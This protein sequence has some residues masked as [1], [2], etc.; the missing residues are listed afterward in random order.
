MGWMSPLLQTIEGTRRPSTCAL[1]GVDGFL[2]GPRLQPVDCGEKQALN[3]TVIPKLCCRW[4]RWHQKHR[5]ETKKGRE[6]EIVLS[7][8]GQP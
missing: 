8:Q 5:K 3:N 1:A 7:A 2:S 6:E 4:Q